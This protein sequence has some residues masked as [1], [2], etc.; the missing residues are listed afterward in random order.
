MIGREAS[1][2]VH[3]NPPRSKPVSSSF[4]DPPNQSWQGDCFIGN[5]TRE[6]GRIQLPLL[7]RLRVG[8]PFICIIPAFE[9]ITA[10]IQLPLLPRLR[11]RLPFICIVPAFE[12]SQ[13]RRVSE[14]W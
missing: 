10:S 8:L 6:R 5:P 7:P 14:K 13:P 12:K 9:K 4:L 1:V 2:E 11:V 3:I